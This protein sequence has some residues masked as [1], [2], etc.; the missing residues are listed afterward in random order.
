MGAWRINPLHVR[1]VAT[2][3]ALERVA[4]RQHTHQTRHELLPVTLRT[5]SA[6]V[7]CRAAAVT[8]RVGGG[9]LYRLCRAYNA[10]H[11][12]ASTSEG[13][14]SRRTGY[15]WRPYGDPSPAFGA[16]PRSATPGDRSQQASP[17]KRARSAGHD[18]RLSLR[19]ATGLQQQTVRAVRDT[20]FAAACSNFPEH[21]TRRTDP[22][23]LPRVII[24]DCER[25][26]VRAAVVGC[27]AWLTHGPFVFFRSAPAISRRRR[28]IAWNLFERYR[29]LGH[30]SWLAV[31]DKRTCDP[32][33][34]L[35]SGHKSA[36]ATALPAS[37]SEPSPVKAWT[38]ARKWVP[39]AQRAVRVYGRTI[40][41]SLGLRRLP[42]SRDLERPGLGP[43]QARYRALPQSAW[44]L[45]RSEG[46][47]VAQPQV[48]LVLTLHDAWLLSGH[49][50]HSF[51]CE[52]WKIG[53]GRCPDL[54]IVPAIRRDA[55]AFN[56][57]RKQRF[58]QAS[59]LHLATPSRWLMNKVMESMLGTTN[60][61]VRVIPNGVDLTTFRPRRQE[62]RTE[63]QIA[64]DDK[65]IM[66]AANGIRQNIWKDYHTARAAV[67]IVAER[68]GGQRLRFLA[69]GEDA[70][71]QQIGNAASNSFRTRADRRMWLVIIRRPMSTSM[72]PE[73]IRFPT[74]S[75]RRSPAEHRLW[76]PR[77]AESR[78]RSGPSTA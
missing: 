22:F 4:A 52:R 13:A 74:P 17:R 12:V 15:R 69:L 34:L 39:V 41:E 60:P 33:V 77:L 56:W 43:A 16:S 31:G 54:T 45:L 29:R 58:Y 66:F 59:R 14:R 18:L 9:G 35:V 64:P 28:R 61:D 3:R 40:R 5:P 11:S 2:V 65:V 68:M 50:A 63:L 37:P 44:R 62:A 20:G 8:R 30:A 7:G 71:C 55:T 36:A 10:P 1:R 78:S 70:P 75:S 32:D 23:Q 76:R 53:C 42:V 25:R 51:D 57:R 27:G 72:R 26:C 6:A 67:A 46:I 38:E 48:P 21:I 73:W 47:A 24:R 19:V 49:C